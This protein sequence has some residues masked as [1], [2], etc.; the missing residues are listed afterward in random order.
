MSSLLS[1]GRRLAVCGLAGSVVFWAEAQL[2]FPPQ[3]GEF[4]LT[5][6]L[7]G[8]QVA[9][10]LA[11][12]PAGGYVVW[13]DNAT[14]GD[15]LGI[16]ARAVNSSFSPVVARSFRVNANGAGNQEHPKAVLLGDGG[17]LFVWQG[18]A[19]GQQDIYARVLSADGTFLTE[20][21]LVNTYTQGQQERPSVTLLKNGNVLVVWSSQDQDGSMQGV[22]GQQLTARGEMVGEEFRVNQFTPYNQRSATLATLDNGD[23]LVAWVSEQQR[24][25]LSADIFARRYDGNL[26]AKAAEFLVNSTT[27]LCANPAI[28][29]TADGGF[30]VAWSQRDG[31]NYSGSWDVFARA[32]GSGDQSFGAARQLNS[33]TLGPQCYPSLARVENLVLAVWMSDYQDGSREG[34]YGRFV[35]ASGAL[36][37]EEF[38]VNTTTVSRQIHPV[39]ASDGQDRFLVGWAT[40]LGGVASFEIFAQRY[41]AVRDIPVPTAPYVAALDAN[42]LQ[43]TWP[44]LAGYLDT[45]TYR[46]KVDGAATPI[47]MTN[48]V[49]TLSGLAPSTTHTFQLAYELANGTTSPWSG[50]AQARTWGEDRKSRKRLSPDGIPDEWQATY[51]GDNNQNWPSLDDDSDGDGA[52]NADEF[53]AGTNPMDAQSVLRTSI[54][55]GQIG[56][57]VTWTSQPGFLYE[58]QVSTNLVNWSG[59]A[60]AQFAPAATTSLS[61]SKSETAAY[62]RVIRIR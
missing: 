10:A 34:V 60:P 31:V 42:T 8:D 15:G 21:V 23:V 33:Y 22:Y 11:L 43:V 37:G 3:E 58:V 14:D 4:S 44:E 49:F 32:F 9:P 38:R 12:N 40:Y 17:A 39:V 61:V 1:V 16:S 57:L 45:V 24:F 19:L 46:L 5:R 48:A 18:G 51:W 36:A 62:Y 30:V 54:T 27:N 25:E 52:L 47:L 13:Q 2:A 56:L 26:N 20:D 55:P 50:I 41:A 28:A 53:L 6:G 29:A 59:A 35:K 7:L